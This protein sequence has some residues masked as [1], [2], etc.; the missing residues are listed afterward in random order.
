MPLETDHAPPPPAGRARLLLASG[1]PRR[2]QLL[3]QIGLAPQD[4][5]PTASDETPRHREPP[6]RYAERVAQEK[7][8]AA[9][10]MTRGDPSRAQAYILAA[11]TVVALGARILPK[12][13]RVEEAAQCLRLLSGRAHRV[14]TA[15]VVISP[16]GRRSQRLV[17]ARVHFKPL[18]PS[19]IAAYLAGGEWAGKAGGYAIQG[20][21]GGFVT[22]IIGSYPAIV[23]LPLYETLALLEGAGFPLRQGQARE[24]AG[25]AG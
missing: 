5:L 3:E 23:G 25:G 18:S 22:R 17:E 12:V 19:E 7:A 6:R 1:S 15:V 16:A 4:V 13:E 20:R 8:A 21:A 14:Y 10:A 24:E 9:Y 2:Y 11:D